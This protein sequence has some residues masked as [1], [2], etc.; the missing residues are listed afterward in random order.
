[1]IGNALLAATVLSLAV[2]FGLLQACTFLIP[3]RT[4]LWTVYGPT[5][6]LWAGLPS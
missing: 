5:L 2:F 4:V 3:H 1:M 6:T